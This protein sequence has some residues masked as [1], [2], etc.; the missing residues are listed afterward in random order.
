MTNITV[1]L[2]KFDAALREKDVDD[3]GECFDVSTGPVLTPIGNSVMVN[4]YYITTM[5]D[6]G[7]KDGGP[8]YDSFSV[9]LPKRDWETIIEKMLALLPN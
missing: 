7:S 5:R 9:H 4:T 2:D 3:V 8:L 6:I 1:S